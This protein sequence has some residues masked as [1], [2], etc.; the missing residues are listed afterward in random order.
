MKRLALTILVLALACATA[1]SQN[2]LD[3]LKNRAKDAVENNLGNK[4]EKGIDNLFNGKS[5]KDRKDKKDDDA[6]ASAG[7]T[8]AA[9][10]A[11]AGSAAQGGNAQS[12]N[13]RSGGSSGQSGSQRPS[14][15][16]AQSG[17]EVPGAVPNPYTVFDTPE[18]PFDVALGLPKNDSGD[19][20]AIYK[21]ASQVSYAAYSYP[22]IGARGKQF[23]NAERQRLYQVSFEK[24]NGEDK[25]YRSL[26]IVDSMAIYMID[27]AKKVITK[28]PVSAV[29][30]MANHY[31][32]N[33][34]TVI[35]ENDISTSQG[36]W[37]YRH[38]GATATTTD[39]AGHVDTETTGET[40]YTDLETGITIEVTH[41]FSHDYTR[42]IHLGVFYPEIFELPKGYT[43]VVQD[44]TDGLRK[45]DEMEA[46][47][48]AAGEKMKEMDL[49][50]K[51]LEELLQM[52][53]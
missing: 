28:I 24:W 29:Q 7:N 10:K 44:F 23:W 9:D 6:P 15:S 40:T 48:K 19:K 38:T 43:M 1:S 32:I 11:A 31:V 3:R 17:R 26:A 41:G 27:D 30:N 21:P 45:M 36:R 33:K 8:G 12:A 42:N 51:S 47:Y 14:G 49:G 53:K 46:K 52:I 18:N 25:I 16:S 22:D 50:D 35:S 2:M 37:C 4:L 13:Q 5:D 39:I 34:E 20:P